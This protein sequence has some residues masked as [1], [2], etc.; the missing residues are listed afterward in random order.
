MSQKLKFTIITYDMKKVL[1]IIVMI[2]IEFFVC[3]DCPG[4]DMACLF[5]SYA[6]LN[7]ENVTPTLLLSPRVE[8]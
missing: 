7:G 1:L 6:S 3:Q 2:H 4:E 8:R 5:V